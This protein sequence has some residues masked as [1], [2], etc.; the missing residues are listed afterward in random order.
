[1]RI[2]AVVLLLATGCSIMVEK[3]E[4]ADYRWPCPYEPE[5]VGLIAAMTEQEFS[6]TH[7]VTVADETDDVV[8]QCVSHVWQNSQYDDATISGETI[9]RNTVR[10]AT[11][12]RE[13]LDVWPIGHTSLAHE[14]VHVILW[15]IEGDPHPDH[16]SCFEIESSVRVRLYNEEIGCSIDP[17]L[18]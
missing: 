6:R 9:D 4:Y 2:I 14:F 17:F 18:P 3:P 10:I 11:Q 15:R 13:D 8:V 12:L 7:G 16:D 5:D 1:M